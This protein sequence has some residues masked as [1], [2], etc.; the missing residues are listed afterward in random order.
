[1]WEEET[2]L[3]KRSHSASD[4]LGK[5]FSVDLRAEAGEREESKVCGEEMRF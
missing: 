4:R 3:L 1:M 5:E 2:A